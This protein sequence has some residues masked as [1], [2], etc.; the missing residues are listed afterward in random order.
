MKFNIRNVLGILIISFSFTILS[1][2]IFVK[3]PTDNKDVLNTCIG[4]VLGSAITGVM[5]Y[6]YN[7]SKKDN[8][9]EIYQ[10]EEP[11]E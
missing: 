11:K 10:K 8:T 6:F 7:D 9:L 1:L 2:L 3:I 4:M 5:G